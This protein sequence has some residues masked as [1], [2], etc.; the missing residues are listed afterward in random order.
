M[1]FDIQGLGTVTFFFFLLTK[2]PKS[3]KSQTVTFLLS[4]PLL[5]K[6]EKI[7]TINTCGRFLG[8]LK[9]LPAQTLGSFEIPFDDAVQKENKSHP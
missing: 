3:P 6:F 2:C 7:Q 4:P 5:K 1:E 8:I 9:G